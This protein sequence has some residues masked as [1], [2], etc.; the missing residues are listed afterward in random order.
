MEPLTLSTKAKKVL[1]ADYFKA[2][3]KR[4]TLEAKRNVLEN[5]ITSVQSQM[6]G[7][8]AMLG[9]K[10]VMNSQAHSEAVENVEETSNA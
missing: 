1:E 5:E 8:A 2:L 10:P 9:Y 6:D 4:M 3:H 7:L